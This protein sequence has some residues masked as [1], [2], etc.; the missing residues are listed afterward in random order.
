MTGV[1]NKHSYSDKEAELNRMI[2]ENEIQKLAIIVCDINGLKHVN[3]T[4]GHAAGDQLIKDASALICEYFTH[5]TVFRTG[6]DEFVILLQGKGYDIMSEVIAGFNQ[7]VEENIEKKEVVISIGYSVLT[8]GDRQLRDIFE[9]ADQMM[10]QRKKELKEM[11][12]PT[13]NTN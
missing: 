11:G 4:L 6:G 10:Y 7:K 3:D 2:R 8:P 1:R 13:R 9:R 5:G 12:A